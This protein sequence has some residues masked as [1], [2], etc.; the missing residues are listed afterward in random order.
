MVLVRCCLG[1]LAAA[2]ASANCFYLLVLGVAGIGGAGIAGF[3]AGCSACASFSCSMGMSKGGPSASSACGSPEASR[4]RLSSICRGAG[5]RWSCAPA[6]FLDRGRLGMPF[7]SI[8]LPVVVPHKA[9][10]EVSK[11]GNYKRGALL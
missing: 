4:T 3:A 2:G 7:V 1:V 9:A 10:V 8:D 11:I 5:P 6:N